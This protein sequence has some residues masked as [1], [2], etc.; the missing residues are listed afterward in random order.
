MYM[1]KSFC[2]T[3]SRLYGYMN[4]QGCVAIAPVYDHVEEFS[5]GVAVVYK[6]QLYGLIGET[7]NSIL[8]CEY[9]RLATNRAGWVHAT[10]GHTHYLLNTLGEEALHMSG[11]LFWYFPEAG[12]IRVKKQSG[13]GCINLNGE[14]VI[15]F[16]YKSLGPLLNGWLSFFEDGKWGWLDQHGNIAVVAAFLEVGVWNADL[17]WG[18]NSNG[19][20]L[21]DYSGMLARNERWMKIL[22]PGE[23]GIA[24]AKTDLGWKFMDPDFN[25]V[26]QL[27]PE[28]ERVDYFEEGMAAVKKANV[29]G[30]IDKKGHEVIRAAYKSVKNFSEGMA[31]VKNGDLWGYINTDGKLVIPHTFF[32]A[33]SFHN[34]T[35]WVRGNWCE[36]YINRQG[37]RVSEKKCIGD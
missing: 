34:G 37:E 8:D 23:N 27:P 21:Y 26:L 10:K 15:P 12:L 28:Y 13:W 31:A 11:I 35:A 6:D 5:Y 17:W 32:E 19:Y 9:D 36:W 16:Q 1:L 22:P 24:A 7:G 29:W 14:T 25:A 4:E 20:A 18:R 3:E 30:F 33:T 2:D